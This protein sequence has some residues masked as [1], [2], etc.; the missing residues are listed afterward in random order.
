MSIQFKLNQ[1]EFF[2]RVSL[3]DAGG[4]SSLMLGV[5]VHAWNSNSQGTEAEDL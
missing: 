5:V 1:S 3:T 4:K 2:P